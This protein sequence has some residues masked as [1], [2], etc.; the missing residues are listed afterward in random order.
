MISQIFVGRDGRLS[1]SKV[2]RHIAF[3]VASYVIVINAKT[4]DWELLLAYMA[5][6]SGSEIAK[7]IVQQRA[8]MTVTEHTSTK[9]S[10]IEPKIGDGA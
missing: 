8:G 4:M 9:V 5:I 7:G 10:N 2:W 6:V 1:T 3:T